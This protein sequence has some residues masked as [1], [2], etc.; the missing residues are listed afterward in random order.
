[1]AERRMLVALAILL[2][3]ATVVIQ[4][5]SNGKL[6]T[7]SAVL[8]V[9]TLTG[10]LGIISLGV[11]MLMI[12]GEFDLSVAATFVAAPMVMGVLVS[13]GRASIGAAVA[14]GLAV[15][16]FIGLINGLLTIRTGLP[17]FIV[18]LATLFVLQTCLRLYRPEFSVEWIGDS[19]LRS[20]FAGRPAYLPIATSALWLCVLCLAMWTL[21]NRTR[22]GNWIFASGVDGGRVGRSMGVPTDR[23][24]VLCFVACAGLSG[25]AGL[26]QF[27][28][29]GLVTLTSG[30]EYNLLAIVA[31]VIGGT[32]L[33][34]GQGN[35]VGTALGATFVSVLTIGLV[36]VG[37]PGDWYL[38][39]IGLLLVGAS[40]A[41]ARANRRSR[42]W[43]ELG[44]RLARVVKLT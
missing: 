23:T 20:L 2:T 16:L 32:S 7:S 39:L 35:V 28:D 29:Y 6:L 36:L 9:T 22:L 43:R 1:M 44:P 15:A 42:T 34:G 3:G 18:T 40:V 30:A 10:T 24:K 17:S 31:T 38:G 13:D 14:A 26:L 19:P 8:S 33:F 27:A 25:L 5:L 4:V 37:A 21:L 41:N 11:T 12:A